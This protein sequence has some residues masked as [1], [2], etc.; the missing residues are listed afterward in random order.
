MYLYVYVCVCWSRKGDGSASTFWDNNSW[1]L[2]P[3]NENCSEPRVINADYIRHLNPNVKVVVILR[4]PADRWVAY[5]T[6]LS[7]D[8]SLLIH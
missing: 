3:G 4:N 6:T 2:L 7:V 1:Y 8:V 5:G